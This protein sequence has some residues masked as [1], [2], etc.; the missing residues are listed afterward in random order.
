MGT[1][2]IPVTG[3][4]ITST[5]TTT[6][7]M[8]GTYV[9]GTATLSDP[10]VRQIFTD[11]APYITIDHTTTSLNSDEIDKIKGI[12]SDICDL[13]AD[14]YEKKRLGRNDDLSTIRAFIESIKVTEE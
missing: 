13:L 4:T 9:T 11:Y 14:L 2:T 7:G 3:S 6:S 10:T 1:Y 8:T 12:L 5:A